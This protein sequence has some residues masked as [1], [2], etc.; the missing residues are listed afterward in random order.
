MITGLYGMHPY[1]LPQLSGDLTREQYE[2]DP[3]MWDGL[4]SM[5]AFL[6][7]EKAEADL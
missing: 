3:E 2:A 5:T 6:A 1:P 7:Q 4:G